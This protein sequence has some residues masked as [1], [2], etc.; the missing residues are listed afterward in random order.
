MI[1]KANGNSLLLPTE[2][3]LFSNVPE[4]IRK[5]PNMR[6]ALTKTKISP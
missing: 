4:S 6:N 1:V 2:F 3:C 5:G